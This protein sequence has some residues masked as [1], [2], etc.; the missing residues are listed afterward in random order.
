[1]GTEG[2]NEGV[3]REIQKRRVHCKNRLANSPSPAGM[4]LTKLS[5]A[6]TSLLGKGKSLTFFYCVPQGTEG[7]IKEEERREKGGG[8]GGEVRWTWLITNHRPTAVTRDR[9]VGTNLVRTGNPSRQDACMER[10]T[11]GP[12]SLLNPNPT[13]ANLTALTSRVG[14]WDISKL[15]RLYWLS[16]LTKE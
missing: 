1:M 7:G 4:S 10:I 5:L 16:L 8:G 12:C 14:G 11:T 2:R 15:S 9:E 13:V 3:G 6:V